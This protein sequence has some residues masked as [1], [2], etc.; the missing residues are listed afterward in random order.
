MQIIVLYYKRPDPNFDIW[1]ICPVVSIYA[2]RLEYF[3]ATPALDVD[4]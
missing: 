3:L 4:I 1:N 2:T